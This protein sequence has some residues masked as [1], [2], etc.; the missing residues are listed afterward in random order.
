MDT[1]EQLTT[2]ALPQSSSE[3]Y[4]DVVITFPDDKSE[5]YMLSGRRRDAG[6]LVLLEGKLEEKDDMVVELV[7]AVRGDGDLGV[8]G[9]V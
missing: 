9:S 5:P 3:S 4:A 8:G 2:L 7:R 1:K 6:V